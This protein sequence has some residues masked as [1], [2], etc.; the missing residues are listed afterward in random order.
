MEQQIQPV[1]AAARRWS[2]ASTSWTSAGPAPFWLHSSLT[3]DT[4]YVDSGASIVA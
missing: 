2:S 3:G 1:L 4:V